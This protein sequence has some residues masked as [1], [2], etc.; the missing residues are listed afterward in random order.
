[1]TCPYYQGKGTSW[2]GKTFVICE[3]TGEA[4]ITF[5]ENLPKDFCLRRYPLCPYYPKNK[6]V[7]ND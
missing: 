4:L 1:M 3:G 5:G 7:P 6:E 2:G